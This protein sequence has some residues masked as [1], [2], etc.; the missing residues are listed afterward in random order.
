MAVHR[1]VA[2]SLTIPRQHGAWSVLLLGYALGVAVAGDPGWPGLLLL[3][4]LLG[5]LPARH[6]AALWLRLPAA[7][8]RRRGLL[9]WLAGYGALTGVPVALLLLVYHRWMLLPVGTVAVLAGLI[10]TI[11]ERTRRDRS[12]LGELVGMVGLSSA[13]PAAACAATGALSGQVLA[14]WLLAA[15]V[16]C[17]G[18]FHVRHV[19]RGREQAGHTGAVSLLYHLLANLVPLALGTASVLPQWTF[20]AL[21]PATLRAAWAVAFPRRISIRRLGFEEL[22]YGAVFVVVAVFTV[23]G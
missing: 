12:L 4:S 8:P 10:L 1:C 13:V 19:V 22:A 21:V 7:D 17:G 3:L 14:V 16:F 20:L 18:V 11:L 9:L 6:T 5:A 2:A 15:L 23:R